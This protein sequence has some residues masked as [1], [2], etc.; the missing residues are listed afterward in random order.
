MRKRG[1]AA[2]ANAARSKNLDDIGAIL[3]VLLNHGAQFVG[4]ASGLATAKDRIE[5]GED[6]RARQAQAVDGIAEVF[7][8]RRAEALHGSET[9]SEHL[10]TIGGACQDGLL[11]GLVLAS[12]FA[13]GVEMPGRVDVGINPAGQ[14]RQRGEVV[15]D[16][17]LGCGSAN[18]GNFSAF[19]H[20][21]GVAENLP[22]AIEDGG[23]SQDDGPILGGCE[24]PGM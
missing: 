17:A 14:N 8:E 1:L 23:D 15:S 10:P 12:E 2:F 4:S 21:H 16:C 13:G 20:D 9:G 6:M 11:L 3:R 5:R 24:I 19:D 18:A 7:V 22:S